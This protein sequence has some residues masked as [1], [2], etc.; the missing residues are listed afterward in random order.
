MRLSID[1]G[2]TFTDL[3]LLDTEGE[4]I[5][6]DKLPSTPDSGRAVV[7]G[8]RRIA[9][10]AAVSPDA[11]EMVFHGFTIATNAWLT[12]SGARVVLAVT[13][14]YGDILAIGSQRRPHTYDL[15]AQK[16][17][18]LIT[19]PQVVE[20]VERMDAFGAVVEPL[21]DSELDRVA[22][23]IAALEPEAVAV[24]FLF[25][26]ANDTHEKRL[27]DALAARLEGIPV[28]CSAD[29]DPRI[30]EYPRTNTTV[31]AAY[32][33][34]P[35]ARYTDAL[36][37]ELQAGGIHAPVRYMRSDG[38]AATARAARAN[39]GHMLLSGPAGG[40]VAAL[41]LG[42]H[43]GVTNI[44]NFDM[45]GTSADFS[46]IRDGVAG[47]VRGR[48]LDGLPLRLPML[49]LSA[50]SA[51]GGSIG[52]V[53]RGG[54]LQVGPASAGAVPG[55]ACYGQGGTE[56][57]LTDAAVALGLL[58]SEWFAGGM[59]DS[60][61]AISALKTHVA[62]PLGLNV[63]MAATGMLDVATANMVQAIRELSTE[64]GDDLAEFALLSFGGAGGLFAGYLM[65]DLG[66]R[67]VLV[68]RHP[69]VFAA[70]GL[71]YADLRHHAHAP[72]S[73]PLEQLDLTALSGDMRALASRVEDALAD[74]GVAPDA[75]RLQFSADLRYVGQHHELDLELPSPGAL[76]EG[77]RADIIAAFHAMHAHR[78]GYS[79]DASPVEMTSVHVIGSGLQP[80]PPDIKPAA[81][82]SMPSP[83]AS[84]ELPLGPDH[85]RVRSALYRREEL[86][87][88]QC[89]VGPA[90]LVQADTT[91]LVLSDQQAAVDAAGGVHV[92]PSGQRNEV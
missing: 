26:W 65:R 18:P 88:G 58:E 63:E 8:I 87:P 71:L 80:R 46:V 3:V 23:R 84:R 15:T 67:E 28:Y 40:V 83:F 32:V 16:P 86:G 45:G 14:G 34:P 52:W 53:D 62:E 9:A 12:R 76:G 64:R 25:S 30:E 51:G 73:A 77:A 85:Q 61:L 27:R 37:A 69:G 47:R 39:P 4:R 29:V 74:D 48:H 1:V 70:L 35:V 78:Y 68:P 41:A 57:T 2:G 7:E 72:F 82:T 56:A 66:L 50:I 11:L 43:L 79:H 81:V 60:A 36:E 5:F 22:S 92:T 33:G 24:C 91:V 55:P 90:V 44:V 75:R 17:A 21:E 59:L 89:I 54:G 49:E 38:G 31:A 6:V 13:E 10:Q 42:E 20:V 19:R